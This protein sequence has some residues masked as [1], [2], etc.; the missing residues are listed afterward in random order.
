VVWTAGT[1]R[2]KKKITGMTLR[3]TGDPVRINGLGCTTREARVKKWHRGKKGDTEVK[4][5]HRG[6]TGDLQVKK[7]TGVKKVAQ[8]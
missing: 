8:R 3:T 5:W 7:D 1:I 2:K 4:M 6:K